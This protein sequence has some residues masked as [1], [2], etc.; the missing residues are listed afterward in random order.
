[1]VLLVGNNVKMIVFNKFC[2]IKFFRFN[3]ELKRYFDYSYVFFF[4]FILFYLKVIFVIYKQIKVL[5]MS[6]FV[7]IFENVSFNF[8]INNLIKLI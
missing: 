6:F 5:I 3:F 1:M 7:L 4:D 2:L 8:F